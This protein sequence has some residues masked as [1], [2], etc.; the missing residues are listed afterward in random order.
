MK[1]EFEVAENKDEI[2][3]FIDKFENEDA[4]WKFQFEML[5][6]DLPIQKYVSEKERNYISKNMP[7]NEVSE[8]IGDNTS[9]DEIM[10][11]QEKWDS[12]FE[13]MKE[14]IESNYSY[15]IK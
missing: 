8:Y 7:I 2:D 11:V 1:K 3:D 12:E 4:Y 9:A 13:I 15:I 10:K 5:K 6:K 14:S